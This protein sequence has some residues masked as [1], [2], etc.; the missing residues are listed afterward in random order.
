M[1]F[2]VILI[3]IALQVAA[4]FLGSQCFWPDILPSI[5]V[6]FAC[7]LTMPTVIWLLGKKGYDFFLEKW[8]RRF[9][10]VLFLA[11]AVANLAYSLYVAGYEIFNPQT[12]VPVSFIVTCLGFD[13][14]YLDY[15]Y[16]KSRRNQSDC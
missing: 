16:R 15:Q 8:K 7:M 14:C 3:V 13:S 2:A 5:I 1:L 6:L 11:G 4:I 12:F 10:Y 9:F